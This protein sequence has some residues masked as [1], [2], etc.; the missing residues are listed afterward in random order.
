MNRILSG[1]LA[2]LLLASP[3]ASMAQQNEHGTA[4]GAP[5][6]TAAPVI[7][8]D[9]EISGAYSRATLPNAP[10]GA[11]YLS[12]TNNGGAYDTLVSA[13]SP[14]AGVTQI[15]QMKMEGDVMKMSELPDGVVIAAGQ[16]VSLTP[17]GLHIMFMQLNEPLVEGTMIP[18]TLKFAYAG[19][20]KVSLAVGPI[21]ASEPSHDMG[22]M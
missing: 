17:G 12:I 1:A 9:L 18:V 4:A 19:T 8:G 3:V 2:L 10:V 20:V 14:V 7:A 5:P 15:H 16:S 22:G 21:N 13:S 6:A 11:G